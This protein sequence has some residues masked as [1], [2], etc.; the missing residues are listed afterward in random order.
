MVLR[1]VVR[2]TYSALNQMMFRVYDG[3]G[4]DVAMIKSLVIGSNQ[5]VG[6]LFILHL[7]ALEKTPRNAPVPWHRSVAVGRLNGLFVDV[8]ESQFR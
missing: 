7:P 8:L 6:C 4:C 5:K 3:I 1:R 2:V